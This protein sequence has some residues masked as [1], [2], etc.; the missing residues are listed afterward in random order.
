MAGLAEAVGAAL[1]MIA[2]VVRM[3][4]REVFMVGTLL[5]ARSAAVTPP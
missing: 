3:R 2:A 1:A 5:P 4:R